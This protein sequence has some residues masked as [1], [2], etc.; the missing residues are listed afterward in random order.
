[1]LCNPPPLGGE[2]L[3]VALF[4]FFFTC[5][6]SSHWEVSLLYFNRAK[7]LKL[8]RGEVGRWY[9]YSKPDGMKS[10]KSL[11]TRITPV[12]SKFLDAHIKN[13]SILTVS[14]GQRVQTDA[15]SPARNTNRTPCFSNTAEKKRSVRR[16]RRQKSR[17]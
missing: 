1:M 6:Q 15:A 3:G 12:L 4:F 14:G 17:V 5:S 11:G 13:K 2:C 10:R 9:I 8:R 16:F 7:K